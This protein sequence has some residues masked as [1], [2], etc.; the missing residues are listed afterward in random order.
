MSSDSGICEDTDGSEYKLQI[1][2]TLSKLRNSNLCRSP[3]Q[4]WCQIPE[5][6]NSELFRKLT[7]AERKLQEAKF[8]VITSEISYAK[9]LN[10]LIS[11]FLENLKSI[12]SDEDN[13]TIFANIISVKHS[14]EKF[15]IDLEKC[16]RKDASLREIGEIIWKHAKENFRVYITYCRNQVHQANLLSHL[17][18]SEEF[19][20]AIQDLESDPICQKLTLHCFLILP[21]QR[22]TRMRLLVKTILET[23]PADD[24]KYKDWSQALIAMD[25][26]V[27]DCNDAASNEI[28]FE[29]MSI[30]SKQLDFN[31]VGEIGL[32]RRGRH[33]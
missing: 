1:S 14:T 10:I 6:F 24:S 3:H 17:M 27:Q 13:K 7:L 29:E 32:L 18:K 31:L 22:V 2:Y 21:M 25:K 8:E 15:L 33:L 26:L 30:I 19:C 28:L 23:L 11:H 12:I 4:L 16:W 9:S 5:I 20:E